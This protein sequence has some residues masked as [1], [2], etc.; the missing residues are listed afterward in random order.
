MNLF[1]KNK[2]LDT[3]MAVELVDAMYS[4][5]K[6][7]QL[8]SFQRDAVW[9]EE[10]VQ[11]LWD[12][13]LKN[14]PIGSFLFSKVSKNEIRKIGVKTTQVFR[15]EPARRVRVEVDSTEFIIIDGQQRAISLALGFRK[16][17]EDD[18]ARLW[19]DLGTIAEKDQEE[20]VIPLFVCSILKPWGLKATDAMRRDALSKLGEKKIHIDGNLLGKTWPVRATL[21]VPFPELLYSIRDG[22]LDNWYSLVPTA[23]RDGIPRN[24]LNKLL[25]R[26]KQVLEYKIP[27]FLVHDLNVDELGSVFQRL[28][29]QGVQMNE[30]DLFFSSLKLAW[31]NAHNLVWNIY[32]DKETGRFISPTKIV[33]LAV[34][35]TRVQENSDALRLDKREFKRFINTVDKEGTQYLHKLQSLLR[36]NVDEEV[37]LP[38]PLQ[39]AMHIARQIILYNPS[40]SSGAADP[41]LPVTLMARLRWRVWH[42][43]VAWILNHHIVDNIS[44]MEMIRY[45]LLD[46]FFTKSASSYLISDPFRKAYNANVPFPG[47]EIYMALKEKELIEPNLLSPKQ[48]LFELT[49]DDQPRWDILQQERLLV[50]WCQRAYFQSWFPEFDPTLYQKEHDLPYDIDHI[51]PQVFMNMR[52][53]KYNWPA[54]FWLYRGQMLHGAGNLRYWPKSL[55]RADGNRNLN[56]K[57]LIG[58]GRLSV[59]E[60][61]YLREF[62]MKTIGDVRRASFIPHGD[63]KNWESSANIGKDAYNWSDLPRLYSF[64]KATNN[65]R[66]TMY[67]SLYEQARFSE[68]A[69]GDSR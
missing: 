39:E 35:I 25:E 60:D 52:G 61:S 26:V 32:R 18:S 24:D 43:L 53:R 29:R 20:G 56:D 37:D 66:F 63:T 51:I 2:I 5:Q 54:K 46:L 7:I 31:P 44:R 48:F 17:Q 16:W 42:T 38:G 21:P 23:K 50:M 30:E 57:F 8:P 47:S 62:G 59:P 28:N 9:D 45:A 36:S 65:R 19:I 10:R 27:V 40:S 12:S 6:R 33:H 14:F 11:L 3:I 1:S 22:R 13:I 34:R 69:E 67:K 64:R 49:K 68:W 55:N 58:D 4:N 15:G 41:G